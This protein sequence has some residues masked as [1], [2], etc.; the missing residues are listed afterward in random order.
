[1]PPEA[2]TIDFT[3]WRAGVLLGRLR[4]GFPT[5][6]KKPG[7]FGMLEVEPAFTDVD[8]IM[9]THMEGLPGAPVFQSFLR[10]AHR[11]PGP[12]ALKPLTPEQALGVPRDQAFLIRDAAGAEVPLS[13]LMIQ[14]Y[15]A[16]MTE[17]S[18]LIAVCR[19]RGIAPSAWMLVAY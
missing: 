17:E 12:I 7:I 4:I 14:R 5:S 16:D 3:L 10:D 6:G 9:Q 8:E 13:F 19:E 18:Q 15:P 2:T 11:G 1:M